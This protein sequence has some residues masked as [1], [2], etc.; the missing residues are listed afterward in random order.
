MDN[1]EIW[2]WDPYH[3]E[4]PPSLMRIRR[5]RSYSNPLVSLTYSSA[6]DTSSCLISLDS[7]GKV[8]IW[9]VDQEN[10]LPQGK[11]PS[12]WVEN[13]LPIPGYADRFLLHSEQTDPLTIWQRQEDGYIPLTRSG[14]EMQID[15][16]SLR[17]LA[18]DPT[19][20][21]LLCDYS[22]YSGQVMI[23]HLYSLAIVERIHLPVYPEA[24]C[25]KEGRLIFASA[26]QQHVWEFENGA[27]FSL[28]HPET[29]GQGNLTQSDSCP[30]A[31]YWENPCGDSRIA[32]LN[33]NG[34]IDVWD[35]RRWQKISR[36]P[37]EAESNF[38]GLHIVEDGDD[39]YLLTING[40]DEVHIWDA[41][42]G[43][44]RHRIYASDLESSSPLWLKIAVLPSRPPLV[45]IDEGGGHIG[46][47][48]IDGTQVDHFQLLGNAPTC[49]TALSDRVLAFGM[50]DGWEMWEKV[51]PG[52]VRQ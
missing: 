16:R 37:G 34:D 9:D 2:I 4:E 8:H 20:Q 29:L 49:I 47:R 14:R 28:P 32:G 42:S 7:M 26:S 30:S 51:Q 5:T 3:L 35:I 44:L 46:V 18:I 10:C 27:H 11:D 24:I 31:V 43:V 33:D 45:I 22:D 21:W 19:G 41:E 38:G 17:P 40:N 39:R 12:M 48:T 36:I 1:G 23:C 25:W 50:P 52:D 6:Q 15:N 13:I